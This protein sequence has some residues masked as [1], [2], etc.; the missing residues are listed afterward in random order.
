MLL[1]SAAARYLRRGSVPKDFGVSAVIGLPEYADFSRVHR[2]LSAI[3]ARHEA[4]HARYIGGSEPNYKA[5]PIPRPLD[6]SNKYLDLREVSKAWSNFNESVD[7]DIE[8][9]IRENLSRLA[10]HEGRLT[11]AAFV[12]T[13][14]EINDILILTVHH[15]PVDGVSWTIL[16]RELSAEIAGT[17]ELLSPQM[18]CSQWVQQMRALPPR[19]RPVIDY[20]KTIWTDPGF[21]QELC[22]ETVV[23]SG[24][25]A[26]PATEKI[27]KVL[28]RRYGAAPGDIMLAALGVAI[29]Q[30]LGRR[31]TIL[32]Q[33][34]GRYGHL[35][36]P[37]RID[38][39]NTVGW[40]ADD[41]PVRI[42]SRVGEVDPLNVAVASLP[43]NPED[44]TLCSYYCEETAR[45]FCIE[46]APK[47]YFNYWGLTSSSEG[48]L[49]ILDVAANQMEIGNADTFQL[50][51]QVRTKIDTALQLE[52]I[53]NSQLSDSLSMQITERWV[54]LISGGDPEEPT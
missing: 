22:S 40:L 29:W 45:D 54:Q 44:F 13:S 42:A 48:C 19:S 12:R 26:G 2:A 28:P 4:L 8:F 46:S 36:M 38:V 25:I 18:S 14:A 32:A 17:E 37:N 21:P 50:S 39:T 5:D 7:A 47:I 34:H 41:Y 20:W 53:L 11:A 6:T 43:D 27:M 49:S 35:L 33:G 9:E 52:W 3:V 51:L 23:L 15:L 30:V 1:T 31:P 10:P 16:L 24:S